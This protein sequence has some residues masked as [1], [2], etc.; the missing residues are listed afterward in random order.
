M[1]QPY[2]ACPKCQQSAQLDA[3]I[4]LRCGHQYRTNFVNPPSTVVID[5]IRGRLPTTCVQCGNNQSQ[6]V[7]GIAL[8]GRWDARS[9]GTSVGYGSFSDGG[10]EMMIAT[11]EQVSQ[12]ATRLAQI[13]TP[14]ARPRPP[15]PPANV[16]GWLLVVGIGMGITI[17]V[18]TQ[19]Q[20]WAIATGVIALVCLSA[21][22]AKKQEPEP[23]DSFYE[24]SHQHWQRQ[25]QTWN[26]LYYCHHCDLVYNPTTGQRAPSESMQTILN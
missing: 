11:S 8:A 13:L 26:E 23:D 5:P 15:A 22:Y 14:P 17:L 18:L 25:M 21:W 1:S 6:K 7:S 4:C 20:E 9:E 10:S 24:Q 3:P 16:I 2:K 12:G 19:G